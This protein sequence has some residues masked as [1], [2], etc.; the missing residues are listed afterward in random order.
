[1]KL[2][3]QF[4]NKKKSVVYN[5]DLWTKAEKFFP[6]VQRVFG[7]G[8]EVRINIAARYFLLSSVWGENGHRYT[9][10][11]EVCP[12]GSIG[13]ESGVNMT[14]T[15]W[16]MLEVNFKYVKDFF[17]GKE[18][19]LSACVPEIAVS[20]PVKM[21]LARWF[22]ADNIPL[23]DE[24][25][26]LYY[27]EHHAERE[28]MIR[29]PVPGKDYDSNG[30]EPEMRVEQHIRAA[31]DSTVLMNLIYVHLLQRQIISESKAHCEG[32]QVQSD[33]QF[34]HCLIGSC[35]DEDTDHIGI[36]YEKC[37]SVMKMD[38]MMQLFDEVRKRIRAKPMFSQQLA[39]CALTYI[40]DEKVINQ[41]H[42][43]NIEGPLTPLLLEVR[44]AASDLF[45]QK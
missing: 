43:V 5:Y 39:K 33:S 36:Y 18:V 30:A 41:L 3:K 35:M 13:R 17:E 40:P 16:T 2:D 7:D 45:D 28:C 6:A 22:D 9:G 8:K 19:D 4:Y 23:C 34:D 27:S 29:K 15:E 42:D 24:Q 12:L 10:I 44:A 38:E 21:Y 37:K 25:C 11:H 14:D 1:M 26:M 20:D 32:C 31:P